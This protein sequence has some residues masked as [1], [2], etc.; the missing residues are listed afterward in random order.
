MGA[1]GASWDPIVL[2]ALLS[3]IVLQFHLST[4]ELHSTQIQYGC[5]IDAQPPI[6]NAFIHLLESFLSRSIA[7]CQ[8]VTDTHTSTHKSK[9]TSLYLCPSGVH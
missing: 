7:C 6:H 2:L 9:H 3:L 1:P 5:F 8:G 4:K